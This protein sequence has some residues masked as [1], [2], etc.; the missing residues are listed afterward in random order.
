VKRVA[1]ELP[2]AIR[3]HNPIYADLSNDGVEDSWDLLL[4]ACNADVGTSAL[5]WLAARDEARR[6]LQRG[7]SVN[8]VVHGEI[9]WRELLA[10]LKRGDLA[11][12]VQVN[13]EKPATA[14]RRGLATEILRAF[15]M[16]AP[17]PPEPEDL[18]ELDRYLSARSRSLLVLT[19][20]D[21]AAHRPAY[22]I[23]LFAAL[24]YLVM[25]SR[26][27]TLLV[28][29]RQPFATLLPA[30]HPLSAIDLQTVELRGL[31]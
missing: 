8:L 20:F 1:V 28:Q 9:A 11:D 25:D 3:Q 30:G 21:L 15:G 2:K 12:L 4:R 24:R 27:L 23:D 14:S 26:Q 17:V 29:S 19:H 13:L 22:G 18:G 10:D 6:F 31:S 7:Q 16:T 5:S